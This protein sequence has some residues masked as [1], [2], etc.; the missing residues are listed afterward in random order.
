MCQRPHSK[1][2]LQKADLGGDI[3][4]RWV[5]DSDIEEADVAGLGGSVSDERCDFACYGR[6]DVIAEVE[7]VPDAA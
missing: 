2:Y 1:L 5:V 4:D 6:D 7:C 3:E